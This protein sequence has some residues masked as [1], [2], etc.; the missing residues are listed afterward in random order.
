MKALGS[1]NL[2]I[3]PYNPLQVFLKILALQ[4]NGFCLNVAI[5]FRSFTTFLFLLAIYQW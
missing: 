1:S 4:L 5:P 3:F 2:I